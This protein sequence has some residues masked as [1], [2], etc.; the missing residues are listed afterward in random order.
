MLVV[1][2][3][4]SVNVLADDRMLF[5]AYCGVNLS[6]IADQTFLSDFSVM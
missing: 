2:D 5:L 4:I 3:D 6:P 1:V